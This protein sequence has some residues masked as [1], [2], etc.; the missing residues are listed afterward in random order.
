MSGRYGAPRIGR[1]EMLPALVLGLGTHG[2]AI[3]RSLGRRGVR[4]EV[5]DTAEPAGPRAHTRYLAAYHPVPSLEDERLVDFLVGWA[6][7]NGSPS[8]LF[9]VRDRTVPV[10]SRWREELV[11]LGYRFNLPAPETVALLM[12]KT[13]LP[14]WL[15]GQG[16][17][18]PRAW[19]CRNG[20][21]AQRIGDAVA[22]PCVVKPQRRHPGFKAELVTHRGRLG[23]LLQ[24]YAEGPVAGVVQEW[25]EG[26]TR[27]IR[28]CFVYIRKDGGLAAAFTG[29]KVRQL[30]LDTGVATEMEPFT[31][32]PLLRR[33][34]ELFRAAGY[35][36]FGSTEFKRSSR[37]GR[38]YLI[39]FTVG[40]TDL[41][42]AVART[43]GVDLPWLAYCDLTG[44]PAD[45][46]VP[47]GR[48]GAFAPRRWVDGR[49]NRRALW[50]ELREGR[51][52]AIAVLCS[53]VRSLDPR[54]EFALFAWDDPGPWAAYWASRA[55]AAARKGAGWA[56][57]LSGAGRS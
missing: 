8:V 7:C 19:V 11:R 36:G 3:V 9:L 40:R 55:R 30:P 14:K 22:L 29:R 47:A 48:Q 56:G 12:D 20:D 18:H 27:N 42:L 38:D 51:R 23:D 28:F 33:S 17:P 25:V 24:Q 15:A 39:E 52:G 21:D 32:E 13:R 10:V 5:A 1:P 2:L 45:A 16:V 4:V 57:A 50:Q 43:R 41:N 46:E 34:L 49:R 26:P 37:D 44:H 54:N 35:T 31:D 6:R 53:S